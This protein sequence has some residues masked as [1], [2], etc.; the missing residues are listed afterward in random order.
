MQRSVPSDESRTKSQ[1]GSNED[2]EGDEPEAPAERF[3]HCLHVLSL[4]KR[5]YL[6]NQKQVEVVLT[7]GA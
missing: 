3:S 5:F 2:K 1:N 4:F 7:L 6:E